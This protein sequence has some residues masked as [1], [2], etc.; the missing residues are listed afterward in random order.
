M[1]FGINTYS[2]GVSCGK[3]Q[4]GDT[5]TF[6]FDIDQR[7]APGRYHVNFGVASEGFGYPKYNLKKHIYTYTMSLYSLYWGRQ[8]GE[9]SGPVLIPTKNLQKP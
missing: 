7:L 6:T 3:V 9:W 8:Q 4:A 1:A 2:L 5:I